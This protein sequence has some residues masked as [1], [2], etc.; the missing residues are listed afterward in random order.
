MGRKIRI[1]DLKTPLEVKKVLVDKILKY[2]SDNAYPTRME[3]LINGSVTGKASAGMLARFIVGEGFEDE[4]LNSLVVGKNEYYK[5][6]TLY[7]L[8]TQI[9]KS[10]SKK[11]NCQ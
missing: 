3:R 6:V 2:D 4:S 11:R 1:Q 9:A 5:D 8:L 10:I 7:K